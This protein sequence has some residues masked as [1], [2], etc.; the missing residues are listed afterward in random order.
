MTVAVGGCSILSGASTS[1][2]TEAKLIFR[3]RCT[4][5]H[6]YGKGIKVGPDLKGVTDRRKRDWLL[7]F[8]SSSSSVIQSGDPTATKLFRDF[9]QERM[10]D[11]SD[12]SAE[13][14]AAILDY[15]AAAG[16]LQK[17]PDERDA[18]TATAT[19]IEAG[20]QLFHGGANLKYGGR[21]CHTCHALDGDNP[22]DG[23]LGPNLAGAYLKYRDRALTDFLKHPCF[24]RE[25]ETFTNDYLAPQESFD[26]KAYLAKASGLAIPVPPVPA[27]VENG[28][29]KSDRKRANP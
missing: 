15:F 9:K 2:R 12:L 7:K 13:Q 21:A 6:T 1:D 11:W 17:E 28:A 26:L 22:R 24:A 23:S 10:P 16:P 8:V 4:A 25:P 18:I 29:A 5:C 27:V 19:E 14:I 20:R 3:K